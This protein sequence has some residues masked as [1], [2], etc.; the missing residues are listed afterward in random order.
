MHIRK[1][2]TIKLINGAQQAIRPTTGPTNTGVMPA[3]ANKEIANTGIMPAN[4]EIA[5][6]LSIA[7][8]VPSTLVTFIPNQRQ[9]AEIKV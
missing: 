5:A 4:E 6:I 8:N 1:N 9:Q 7:T 3:N 2:I